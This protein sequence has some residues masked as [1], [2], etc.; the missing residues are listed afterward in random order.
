MLML[1]YIEFGITHMEVPS[2]TTLCIYLSGCPHR[3]KDC[4]YP[5]LQ[6]A[7]SGEVLSESF[8]MILDL[9]HEFTTCVCFM[10]EGDGSATSKAEM[11]RYV[12]NCHERGYKCC[13]YS[14]RDTIIEEWMQK[15]DYVKLG[16]YQAECGPL[17]SV[18][19]NQKMLM[20]T[21]GKYEDITNRF[22][23]Y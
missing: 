3:C 5:E 16:S 6:Q 2:E 19:T 7:D 17:T 8:E 23:E 1:R 10:G 14:G 13:L 20:K 15:F 9:Y 18:T 11:L 4:H 21:Q 22:W 12:N